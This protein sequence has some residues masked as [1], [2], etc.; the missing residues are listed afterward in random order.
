MSREDQRPEDSPEA[1]GAAAA[2]PAEGAAAT[3]PADGAGAAEPADDGAAAEPARDLPPGTAPGEEGEPGGEP[4][5]ASPDDGTEPLSAAAARVAELEAELAAARAALDEAEARLQRSQADFANYRRR[6]MAEQA[7]WGDRAVARLA[8]DLLSVADNL[9]RALDA[10]AST[11]GGGTDSFREGIEL[12]LRQFHDLLSRHGI[13]PIEAV[14]RPF[15]PRFHEAVG[16]I[17]TD[18]VP[19]DHVAAELQRGYTFKDDVLRPSL[20]QVA[21]A[22]ARTDSPDHTDARDEEDTHHGQGRGD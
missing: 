6:M 14:G 22:P 12:T 3:K 8:A 10:L 21:R 15:D 7:R 4:G 2:E 16:Q 19:E 17:E 1:E 18:S 11:P 9:E 13:R 20:V 5:A